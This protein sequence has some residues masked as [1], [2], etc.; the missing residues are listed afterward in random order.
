MKEKLDRQHRDEG[1][2]LEEKLNKKHG[3]SIYE[4]GP[5]QKEY[6]KWHSQKKSEHDYIKEKLDRKR[7][8]DAANVE[9]KLNKKHGRSIYED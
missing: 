3:K 9:E 5:A 4:E 8:D 1:A 7:K 6:D 2:E